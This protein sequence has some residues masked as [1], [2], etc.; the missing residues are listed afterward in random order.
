MNR[1]EILKAQ[2]KWEIQS[3]TLFYKH[4]L[5]AEGKTDTFIWQILNKVKHLWLMRIS[6]KVHK[7]DQNELIIPIVESLLQM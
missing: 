4:N 7:I 6:V 5:W 1:S 2:F 3:K